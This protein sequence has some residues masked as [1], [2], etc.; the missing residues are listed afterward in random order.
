M[1]SG[2]RSAGER[3]LEGKHVIGLFLLM[4]VFSGI[5]FTLGYKMGVDQ[6]NGQVRAANILSHSP[7]PDVFPKSEPAP[8]KVAAPTAVESETDPATSDNAGVKEFWR[9]GSPAKPEPRLEPPPKPA[10]AAPA[11]AKTLNA[12]PVPVPVAPVKNG[13]PPANPPLV[14]SGSFLLQ[15]AALTKQDDALAIASSLQKKHFMAY[16]QPPQKDKFYRVQVGPFK[17]QKTADAAKKGLEGAGYKAFYV[18]H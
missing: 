2:R 10:P 16:V 3:V 9:T 5:F 8:K 15:V 1:A 17:D 13:K 4:L 11:A 14:P 6:F 12:K 7:E 18:K